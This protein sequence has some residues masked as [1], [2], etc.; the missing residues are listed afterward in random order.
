MNVGKVTIGPPKVD[1]EAQLLNTLDEINSTL[2]HMSNNEKR[3][4][5]LNAKANTLLALQKYE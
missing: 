5:L 4:V 1:I 2:K 3:A